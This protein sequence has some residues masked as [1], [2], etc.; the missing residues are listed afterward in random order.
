MIEIIKKTSLAILLF[1]TTSM[2]KAEIFNLQ[3]TI[4]FSNGPSV[5]V[6]HINTDK[7]VVRSN[8]R[9]LDVQKLS[10]NNDAISIVYKQDLRP[11]LDVT[12]INTYYISRATGQVRFQ[13]QTPSDISN[14][15]VGQ[16]EP[17]KANKF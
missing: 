10:V 9:N 7:N 4:E 6:L 8:G 3:C 2:A 14:G 11:M 13:I 5:H 15:A 16:C 12:N 17:R 1:G